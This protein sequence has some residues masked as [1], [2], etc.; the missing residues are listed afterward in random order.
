M[1]PEQEV[2][3]YRRTMSSAEARGL[4]IIASEDSAEKD[5]ELHRSQL[6]LEALWKLYHRLSSQ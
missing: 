6:A 4:R 2:E 5:T 3:I 1:H